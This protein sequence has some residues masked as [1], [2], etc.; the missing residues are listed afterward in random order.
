MWIKILKHSAYSQSFSR[1]KKKKLLD[2]YG[3]NK[4]MNETILIGDKTVLKQTFRFELSE[5]VEM[6]GVCTNKWS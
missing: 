1:N 5:G 2:L 3:K 6:G 4:L